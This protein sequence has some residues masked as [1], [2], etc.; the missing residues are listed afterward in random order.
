M[1]IVFMGAD[2]P[3]NR[4]ILEQSAAKSMGISFWGL[5]TRGFPKTK[6]YL[7]DNYFPK[8]AEIYLYPGIPKGAELSEEE[9]ENFCAD[10]ETFVMENLDRITLFAEV[11]HPGLGE[12]FISTQ[13]A[14]VWADV[15]EDK[16]CPIATPD[17]LESLAVRYLNVGISGNHLDDNA[18]KARLGTYSRL[19]G[20]RFHVFGLA[21]P[22]LLNNKAFTTASTLSWLSPMMRGETIVWANNHLTRYPKRM[23]E[24][25]R[26]RHKS[27]YELAG[28][29]FDKIVSDDAVEVSKLAVWSYQQLEN[30]INRGDE[31]IVT[32]SSETHTPQNAET[33][34]NEVTIRGSK[35]RKLKPR[36]PSEMTTLPVVGLELSRVIEPDE[37]GQSVL[38]EVPVVR[39]NGTSMRVC[40]SCFIKD[41][42]PAFSPQSTCAFSLPIE[43]KTKEQLKGLINSL[44]EIQGQRVMFAKFSED[45]NGGYPDPAVGAEMDRMMKMLKTVKDLDDSKEMIRMTVERKGSGGMLSGLF[46]DK[47]QALNQ[48]PNNGLDE[49][50][51]N[52]VI[53]RITGDKS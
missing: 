6:K 5:L 25:A 22:D 37:N 29:D 4:V 52:E 21:E 16:F 12:D 17:T 23:K 42:C 39:S 10:Y 26:P 33:P 1:K 19:H 7:L 13:R 44:L 24:Q 34:P 8:Y 53:K 31:D 30:W 18:L 2:V 45:L 35:E 28:L 11:D 9:L 43:V 40:D 46:G 3:S 47:A 49:N 41:T 20:T 32:M 50:Q 38:R 14:T 48:L 15:P 27:S 36:S 51:T